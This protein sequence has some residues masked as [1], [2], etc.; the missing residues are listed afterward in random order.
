SR[1]EAVT[2]SAGGLDRRYLLARPR[3]GIAAP[4]AVAFLH[5]TGGTAA[6]A[7][8]EAGWSAFAARQ[9]FVLALP[10]GVPVDP[11]KPPKFL[12]NPPRWNDGSTKPGDRLHTEADDVGFL[13]AVIED[14]LRR[15][16]AD[17]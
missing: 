2:L 14:V 3:D 5:G 15:T 16:G 10:E 7:D 4:P 9:G 13:T 8:T 11:G 12:T 17:P 6:W 1:L